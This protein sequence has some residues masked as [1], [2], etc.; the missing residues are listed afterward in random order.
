[1]AQSPELPD[2][3]WQKIGE[4]AQ[5]EEVEGY[6]II[7]MFKA[8]GLPVGSRWRCWLRP[9]LHLIVRGFAQKATLFDES[10]AQQGFQ[11]TSQAWLSQWVPGITIRGRDNLPL[12][13]PLLIAANHPGTYDGLAIASNLNRLDLKIVAAGNPFFRSL[14]NVKRHF[15]YSTLDPTVRMT[16]IRKALRHLQDGGALLIFPSGKLDPDPFYFQPE[17]RSALDRWSDS[18]E[19]ILKNIPETRLVIAINSQFIAPEFLRNP[20]LKLYK[21]HED[22]QKIAAFIQVIQQVIF[23]RRIS[24]PSRL[25][26]S[27]PAS[28]CGLFQ[29]P[30]GFRFQVTTRALSLMEA[31][32]SSQV[33]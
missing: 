30:E 28:Y 17:A 29:S 1:M 8:L 27:E 18:L 20:L 2:Q 12:S 4:F 19:L 3:S 5:P 13:G 25:V 16:V 6:L 21:K 7:E 14:P 33:G 9:V 31:S 32:A 11:L 23:N 10:V 26:F 15:I 24:C 22:R